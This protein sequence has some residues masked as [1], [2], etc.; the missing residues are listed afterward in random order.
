MK[1]TI[2][3]S[4]SENKLEPSPEIKFL[5]ACPYFLSNKCASYNW[6]PKSPCWECLKEKHYTIKSRTYVEMYEIGAV[7]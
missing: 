4:S 1:L 5:K 2:R 7:R 3:I 6:S